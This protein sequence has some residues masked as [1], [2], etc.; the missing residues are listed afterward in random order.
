MRY[1]RILFFLLFTLSASN[2]YASSI[3]YNITIEKNQMFKERIKYTIASNNQSEYLK[4][5]FD[6]DVFFDKDHKI[7]YVKKISMENNN[8][9]VTLSHDGYITDM[10]KSNFLDMC[11][12]EHEIS[13]DEYSIS[14]YAVPEFK[15]L[16][17]ADSM[18]IKINTG[19]TNIVN[20]ADTV[21]NDVYVWSNINKNLYMNCEFGVINPSSS[22]N[23]PV[24]SSEDSETKN[25]NKVVA[26]VKFKDDTALKLILLT[27][28]GI[29]IIM[30]VIM[31]A[32][33]AHMS[34]PRDSFYDN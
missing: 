20:N 26:D 21:V 18:L 19:I 33:K 14:F 22:V 12:S 9:V 30:V 16:N 3:E 34:E 7:K 24:E 10:N 25:D 28:T 13:F 27:G 17:H 29:A 23:P 1:V 32:R 8:T 15:C 31:V 5:V 2:V 4:S 11:F 6:G